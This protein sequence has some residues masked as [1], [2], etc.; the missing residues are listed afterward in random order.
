MDDI[1]L[2]RKVLQIQDSRAD[3]Q[4]GM[5]IAN[6]ESQGG[7]C[8]RIYEVAALTPFL[9]IPC[10]TQER[11]RRGFFCDFLAKNA[12]PESNV[13]KFKTKETRPENSLLHM[14]M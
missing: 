6:G 14:T 3:L 1:Q 7:Y 12:L 4:Q 10:H 2:F 5:G 8:G 11:K 9:A 13:G